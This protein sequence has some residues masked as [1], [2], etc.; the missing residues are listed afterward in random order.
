MGLGCPIKLTRRINFLELC[1][2]REAVPQPRAARQ[3]EPEPKVSTDKGSTNVTRLLNELEREHQTE[4]KSE[5]GSKVLDL[6]MKAVRGVLAATGAPGAREQVA[7][8]EKVEVTKSA[9]V[10]ATRTESYAKAG[11]KGGREWV[12]PTIRELEAPMKAEDKEAHGLKALQWKALKPIN[13]RLIRPGQ[14]LKEGTLK[15][16][17]ETMK[18]VYVGGMTRQP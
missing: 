13:K 4:L 12:R 6:L 2:T 8:S 7:V 1:C 14:P 11:S 5:K 16:K 18:F 10:P 15:K 17:V 3:S 9:P